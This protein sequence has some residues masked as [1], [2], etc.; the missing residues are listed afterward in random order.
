VGAYENVLHTGK[1]VESAR[2]EVKY[3]E[4]GVEGQ[5]REEGDHPQITQ[6]TQISLSEEVLTNRSK[7]NLRNL[8]NLRMIIFKF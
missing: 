3:S 8:R 5:K 6:I 4:R 7:V 1:T 2:K